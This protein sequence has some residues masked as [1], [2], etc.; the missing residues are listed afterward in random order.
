M[1]IENK[2]AFA[3]LFFFAKKVALCHRIV[4]LVCYSKDTEG[5]YLIWKFYAVKI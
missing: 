5:G 2:L 4:S 1:S 3:G